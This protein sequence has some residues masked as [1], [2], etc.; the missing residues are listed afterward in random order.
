MFSLFSK[1]YEMVEEADDS[2]VGHLVIVLVTIGIF[3]T[4]VAAFLTL[5]IPV[6]VFVVI[7]VVS[8]CLP[9]STAIFNA[10]AGLFW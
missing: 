1:V 2:P 7:S 6:I 3:W 4:M 9:V 8:V 5:V 10:L